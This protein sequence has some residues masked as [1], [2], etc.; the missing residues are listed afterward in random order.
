MEGGKSQ[1]KEATKEGGA[2]ILKAQEVAFKLLKLKR[3][4]RSSTAPDRHS[5]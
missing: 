4:F 1:T 3:M 5:C 2:L